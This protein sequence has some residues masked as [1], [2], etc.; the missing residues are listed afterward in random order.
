MAINTDVISRL[1][2]IIG[3]VE[4][5][6]T[7]ENGEC[8]GEYA[9]VRIKVDISKPL[10]KII[11]LEPEG[12]EKIP[13]PN[14]YERL[15]DFCFCCGTLGHQ[16][17][18][19]IKYKDHKQEDLAFGPWMRVVTMVER[20][21]SKKTKNR[22]NGGN[23][24][25]E[26]ESANQEGHENQQQNQKHPNLD[27][28]NGLETT[29]IEV[30]GATTPTSKSHVAEMGAETLMLEGAKSIEQQVGYD[31]LTTIAGKNQMLGNVEKEAGGEWWEMKNT[32]ESQ[33]LGLMG[34]KNKAQ[35]ISTEG[36]VTAKKKPK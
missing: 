21:N 36:E 2:A 26:E 3:T 28:G 6:E 11:F 5:V 23:N 34:L 30:C 9:R 22:W 7:G 4:E 32:K 17:R 33:S 31:N 18:E 20:A 19:C 16:F 14:R 25:R 1:G 8:I 10:K 29:R 24:S 12:E 35:T 13:M 15:P 27:S